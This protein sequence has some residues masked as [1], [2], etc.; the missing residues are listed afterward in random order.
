MV[1]KLIFA[2]FGAVLI[3]LANAVHEC[4]VFFADANL[5]RRKA[6]DSAAIQAWCKRCSRR[7]S[8]VRVSRD[9]ELI[10]SLYLNNKKEQ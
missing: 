10:D 6:G 5:F 7:N 2:F 8:A 9:K 3:A 4:G 1:T